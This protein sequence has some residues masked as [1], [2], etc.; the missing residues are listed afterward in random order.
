[1]LNKGILYGG[2]MLT[3][4]GLR[5]IEYNARFGDPQVMNVL[6]LLQADFVE[7]CKAIIHG[8]LDKL[9]DHP[10][11]AVGLSWRKLHRMRPPARLEV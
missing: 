10:S 4:D 9:A 1:M 11:H 3:K 7:V 8:T 6:P 2:F 5:V